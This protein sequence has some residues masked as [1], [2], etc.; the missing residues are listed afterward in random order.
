[1]LHGLNHTLRWRGL[2]QTLQN[3]SVASSWQKKIGEGVAKHVMEILRAIF[4]E[5]KRHGVSDKR[6]SIAR[7][8]TW[9]LAA[10]A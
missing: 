2:P 9:I 6:P 7:P 5:Q 4:S 10:R 3:N 8:L 1:M